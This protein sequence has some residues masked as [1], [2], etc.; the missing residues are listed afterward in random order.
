MS[1]IVVS[2]VRRIYYFQYSDLVGVSSSWGIRA[3]RRLLSDIIARL[4]PGPH[5]IV[6]HGNVAEPPSCFE[7]IKGVD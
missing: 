4:P 3:A 7:Q 2:R 1:I 6:W 5:T